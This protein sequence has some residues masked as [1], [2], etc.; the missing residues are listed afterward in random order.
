MRIHLFKNVVM[1]KLFTILVLQCL[2]LSSPGQ[3]FIET[4]SPTN[5]R[6][7]FGSIVVYGSGGLSRAIPYNRIKGTPFWNEDWQKAYFFDSRDTSKGSY[8]AKFNFGNQE[9]HYLNR[10]GEEQAAIPGELRT[11]IFMQ[12]EDSTKIATVF[13]L[14]IEEIRIKANC[15]KCYVQ[16]LNQ[17]DTKLLKITKREVRSA[18]SLFGT[19]KKYYFN[20]TEEYFVQLGEQYN[21]IRRL[22]KD[23]FFAHIPGKTAYEAWIR[24]KGLKFNKESDYIIFLEHYN[25]THIKN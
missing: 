12:K 18:D 21:K 4:G 9:V 11:I 5:P 17:G 13:R 2:L 20:D 25:A 7:A 14:T 10:M 15:K 3:V 16:E 19:Q 1:K 6:D 22:T 8:Q 23:A 24:E